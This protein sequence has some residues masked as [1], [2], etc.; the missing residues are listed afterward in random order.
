MQLKQHTNNAM[1]ENILPLVNVVFLLLIFFMLA[2]AFSR[3]DLFKIEAPKAENDNAADRKILTI[4]INTQGELAYNDVIISD[5]ELKKIVSVE[6]EKNT[7]DALQLKADANMNA[8]RLIDLIEAL[9]DTGL[10]SIHLLTVT[11]DDKL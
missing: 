10:E 9:K 1:G 5:Q 6:V 3:P 2:G 11:P 7:L 8:V 4:L